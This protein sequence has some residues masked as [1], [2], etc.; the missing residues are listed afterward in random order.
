MKKSIKI[1]LTMLLTI[2]LSGCILQTPSNEDYINIEQL[3]N[4][5]KDIIDSVVA[6]M[7]IKTA[8][9]KFDFEY[10]SN[11]IYL[12]NKFSLMYL[13]K[14]DGIRIKFERILYYET[15]HYAVLMCEMKNE[16]AAKEIWEKYESVNP[17]N[18]IFYE[19]NVV[20]FDP[21]IFNLLIKNYHIEGDNF[22]TLDN[23]IF[24]TNISNEEILYIPEVKEIAKISCSLNTNIKK[25]Y[26]STNLEKINYGAFSY[27]FNLENVYLNDG[28]KE[29]CDHSFYACES[30]KYVV[31]PESV[32]KIGKHAFSHGIIYCEALEKPQEWHN[33]FATHNATVIWGNEWEY[34]EDGIPVLK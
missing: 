1:L 9:E 14:I 33:E 16:Q 31:I 17:N 15:N 34:N 25:V 13:K 18:P 10:N 11:D 12:E 5:N 2:I 21:V 20:Y 6:N 26:M 8:A 32:E 7:D 24:L 29:I 27:C 4:E 30:L 23:T 28:L 22:I 19:K 3:Y